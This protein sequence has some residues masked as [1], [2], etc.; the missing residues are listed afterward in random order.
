MEM[1]FT[2][3]LFRVIDGWSC[4]VKADYLAWLDEQVRAGVYTKWNDEHFG[5][6]RKN[7][8]DNG[9]QSNLE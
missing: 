1:I 2:L 9:C 3:N 6:M 4:G 7:Q 5:T 8:D